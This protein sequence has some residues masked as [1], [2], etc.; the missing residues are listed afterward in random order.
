M[1]R[2]A[3]PSARKSNSRAFKI[4]SP[5]N[6]NIT[7]TNNVENIRSTSSI[8]Q[9]LKIKKEPSKIETNNQFE[10]N[11]NVK[12]VPEENHLEKGYSADRIYNV[13]WGK[14]ST[15]KHK[16]WEGDGTVIVTD[17]SVTLKDE[18]GNFLGKL[19]NFNVAV[20]EEDYIF[21]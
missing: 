9:I 1:R 20:I 19:T 8:L 2:S 21:S 10:Q 14:K 13:V 12:A 3:A 6:E 18:E 15:K 7:P 17:K 5:T 16:T 4:S 11:E